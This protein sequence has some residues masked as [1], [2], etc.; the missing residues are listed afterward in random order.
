MFDNLAHLWRTIRANAY[1]GWTILGLLVLWAAWMIYSSVNLYFDVSAP[2]PASK[3]TITVNAPRQN[4]SQ[5]LQQV[6]VF[7]A[8]ATSDI[9]SADFGMKLQA[10]FI[11]PPPANSRAL[12][13]L[14]GQAAQ[15]FAVGDTL[16][17]GARV[18]QILPDS[19]V[20]MQNGKLVKLTFALQGLDFNSMSKP[21]GLF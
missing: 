3:E 18:Y 5:A 1:I 20:L 4:L 15:S 13:V 16:P 17:N 10:V 8:V 7:G 12:I 2:P 19:V 9:P 14:T 6:H 11:N 21:S